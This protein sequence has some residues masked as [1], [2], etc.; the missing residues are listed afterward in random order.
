MRGTLHYVAA[1]DVRWMLP[2]L[3]PRVLAR[4]AGRY[5]QLGLELSLF[6]KCRR[7]FE[8]A[9]QGGGQY[10]R[11]E[12]FGLLRTAGVS[13]AGQRGIHIL[14]RLA[15]EGI[16]CF[17]PR[18]DKQQTFVLLEE[19]I[20]PARPR[21]REEALAHLA[22][23]FF[24][25]HGPATVKDF[26]WW[27]GL[28]LTDAGSSLEASASRLKRDSADGRDYWGP[29]GVPTS[30]RQ[31]PAAVLLPPF[32]ELLVAYKDRSAAVD[33]SHLKHLHS[34]L[35]PT[36][37]VK[38]RI[39]G[40]WTRTQVREGVLIISRFFARPGTGE[41]RAIEAAVHRY[42]TYLGMAAELK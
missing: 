31:S 37:A 41:L 13:P 1:E 28:S 4:T 33:P 23:R 16:L 7:L 29:D 20:A 27:S 15:Q 35:S 38:G 14:Q 9:L 3:T 30:T 10:T 25:S 11:D 34:L 42:G 22:L 26:A 2:L 39:V 5:R 24:N 40:T 36:I 6:P 21:P 32:D 17:G 18:R 12:M 8:K 19:W